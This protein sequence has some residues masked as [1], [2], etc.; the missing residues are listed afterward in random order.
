MTFK[1]RG[2][3]FFS[4]LVLGLHKYDAF[5]TPSGRTLFVCRHCIHMTRDIQELGRPTPYRKRPVA[6]AIITIIL[7]ITA[8]QAII[9]LALK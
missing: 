9:H 6:M 7:G 5:I 1:S 3:R 4:C 2:G 8:S